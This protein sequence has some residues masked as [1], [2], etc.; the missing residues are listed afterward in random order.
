ME[1]FKIEVQE[2]SSK[3]VEIEA[4]DLEQ[5]IIEVKKMYEREEIV[6]DENNYITTE[7]TSY[8]NSLNKF[9]SEVN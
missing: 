2:F 1:K 3:I 7:F 6:L 5:A 9:K 8:E 4:N